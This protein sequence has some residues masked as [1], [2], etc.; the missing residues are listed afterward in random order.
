MAEGLA[1]P[2]RPGPGRRAAVLTASMSTPPHGT[3]TGRPELLPFVVSTL[4]D[5]NRVC[6]RTT[7]S[8]E[9]HI[10]ACGENDLSLPDPSRVPRSRCRFTTGS[11][12]PSATDR[13]VN[14]RP[15]A[16]QAGVTRIASAA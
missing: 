16:G 11:S 14:L 2:Y 15:Q 12:R 10:L 4:N 13:P 5:P 8:W 9:A 3:L 7:Q 1:R 6:L